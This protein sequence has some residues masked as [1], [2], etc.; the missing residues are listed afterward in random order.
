[1]EQKPKKRFIKKLKNK[2]KLVLHNQ[3]TLHESFTLTLTPLNVFTAFSS[4]LVLYGIL[5]VLL[6][7]FTPLNIY[8]PQR[9]DYTA[10][11]KQ[12]QLEYQLDSITKVQH[13]NDEKLKAL[14]FILVG[15]IDSAENG[16]K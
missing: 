4:L 1:M 9:P 3:A 2:Y 13:A 6:L 8:L 16:K 10:L 7:K 15:D 14:Q 12:K 5:I 11:K